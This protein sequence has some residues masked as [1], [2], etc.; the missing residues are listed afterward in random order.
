MK[1]FV[2]NQK[3]V[4]AGLL[5]VVFGAAFSIGAL[6]YTM[7]YPARMGPGWFPFW[8]GI[9]LVI[10]GMLTVS[11]GLRTTAVK[12]DIKRLQLGSLA[13][14]ISAVVLFGLLLRPLGLVGAL[15][16]LVLV[17]SQASHEFTWKSAI[18]LAVAL[19]LFSSAVFIWGINLQLAL[20]PSF[21]E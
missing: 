15:G 6:N 4:A 9:L 13:W 2:R 16:V 1:I 20:W 5:Y 3:D 10:V 18:V 19:I 14:I 7:G 17:S 8:I 21:I 11:T 12:D